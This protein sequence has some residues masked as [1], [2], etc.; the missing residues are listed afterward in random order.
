[1]SLFFRTAAAA[2][3]CSVLMA[4][5]AAPSLADELQLLGAGSLREALTKIAAAFAEKTGNRVKVEFGH[6]GKMRE[7]V[8]SGAP[9]DVFASADMGHPRK[10]LRDG[11]VTLVAEF[12]RNSLCLVGSPKTGLTQ[13]DALEKMMDPSLVLGIFPPKEDPAGDYSLQLFTRAEAVKAGAEA[14]L[15]A[16]AKIISKD[17][18]KGEAVK[19]QDYTITL[20]KQG[21]IDLHLGYCSGAYT[22]L[23]PSYRELLVVN[24]PPELSVGANYGLALTKDAKPQ[25]AHLALYILS[26]DG[27][28]VFKEFGFTPIAL[29]Q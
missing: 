4:T 10:L 2:G 15:N 11:K 27:Q 22:R 17:Q 12:T 5:S 8:E 7:K 25:A 28:K 6:S 13:S 23:R 24:L 18:V 20:L 3:L 26:L 9:A 29:D 21:T 14:A 16:K 1:M 19:G